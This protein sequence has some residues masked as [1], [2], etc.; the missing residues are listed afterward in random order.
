MNIEI[1]FDDPRVYGIRPETA[2]PGQLYASRNG[3]VFLALRSK[4]GGEPALALIK[5][6]ANSPAGQL[7]L[8]SPWA[9]LH[10]RE[11]HGDLTITL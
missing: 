6:G 9:G 7:F 5:E 4:S 1:E 10:L 11:V 2:V 3:S 8:P